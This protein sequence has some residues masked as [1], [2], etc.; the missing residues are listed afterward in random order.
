MAPLLQA[1]GISKRFGDKVVVQPSSFSVWPS[2]VLALIGANG[3]GKSTTLRMLA[4]LA[5]ATSGSIRVGGRE[6][7]PHSLDVRRQLGVLPDGLGLIPRFSIQDHFR[8]IGPTYG[9]DPATV[10]MRMSELLSALSLWDDRSTPIAECS[11]GMRKKCSFAL[12]LLHSPPVLLLDEPL[13]GLDLYSQQ[14]VLEIIRRRRVAG[15]AIVIASHM[16]DVLTVASTDY[17]ILSGGEPVAMGKTAGGRLPEL[18]AEFVASPA[19]VSI[20]W[21]DNRVE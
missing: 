1:A 2:E 9:L 19:E 6:L 10:T 8:L 13:E 14:T 12:S 11:Y 7:T 4:G 18:Y 17:L 16:L 5:T 21:L 15:A 20:A 3:S